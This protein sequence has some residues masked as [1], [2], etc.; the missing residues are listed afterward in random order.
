MFPTLL[1]TINFDMATV[2]SVKIPSFL[3]N[4][5]KLDYWRFLLLEINKNTNKK[6]KIFAKGQEQTYK[7]NSKK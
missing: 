7:K 6:L 2:N 4:E 3:Q 5:K 1:Y